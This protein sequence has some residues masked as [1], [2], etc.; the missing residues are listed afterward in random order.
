MGNTYIEVSLGFNAVTQA[1]ALD[2]FIIAFVQKASPQAM[3]NGCPKIGRRQDA[4]GTP[5]RG[6]P[7]VTHAVSSRTIVAGM[8]E[9]VTFS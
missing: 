8:V 1:L 7:N 5:T 2:E 4:I 9:I 3:P 6:A